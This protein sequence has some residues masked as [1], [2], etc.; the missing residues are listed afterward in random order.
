MF[1]FFVVSVFLN[2]FLYFP[3]STNANTTDSSFKAVTQSKYTDMDCTRYTTGPKPL[4]RGPIPG[5]GSPKTGSYCNKMLFKIKVFAAV[6]GAKF[7]ERKQI[8]LHLQ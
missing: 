1:A 4:G 2:Y 5:H 3:D 8:Q 6:K 7:P